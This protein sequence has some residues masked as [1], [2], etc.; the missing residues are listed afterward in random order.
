MV[1]A[2]VNAISESSTIK[3]LNKE[4]EL[5]KK[6]ENI[7]SFSIGEPDFTTPRNIIDFAYRSMIEG[8]THYTPS[9]G[10]QLLREKIADKYS[11]KYSTDLKATNVLVTPTKFA[12]FISIFS[13]VD[14]GEEVLLP[15]PGWVSYSEMVKM[16]GGIPKFYNLRENDGFSIDQEDLK[17]KINEKTRVIVIN[18]PSNPTGT[19]IKKDDM[20]FL[21]DI[22]MDKNVYI[23][24]DE[25]YD[26]LVYDGN[27]VSILNYHEIF[28]K[29]IFVNGFSKS[30]A[31]TGW[32]IGYMIAEN[33]LIKIFDK[34][35]QHTIT[36]APSVSQYA[37][38][39]AIDDD[40]SVKEMVDEF[41]K[42]R[43]YIYNRISGMKIFKTIIPEATFYIFPKFNLPLN[44]MEFSEFLLEK[45]K[46]SVIPG[47]SFGN[48]GENH[49]RISF[50]T[51]MENIKEGMDRIE[52]T[53]K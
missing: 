17:N 36:C 34:I 20:N 30:H 51:S 15:D 44:S 12:I 41:R 16:A 7:I 23:I 35:Q 18:T 53:F 10:I 42:R 4:N 28:Q 13:L 31:M 50:A 45:A 21:R 2:R 40:K 49:I 38:L 37:A 14:Q 26:K 52:D 22:V 43:D 39:K 46:V 47:I 11:K 8:K 9:S 48:N 25:I 1:S 3:L 5:R 32:R 29:T 33:D 27:F 6:G 24:S 19:I